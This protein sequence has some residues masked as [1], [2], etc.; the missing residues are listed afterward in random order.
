MSQTY[1]QLEARPA[2]DYLN[3]DNF[4]TASDKFPENIARNLAQQQFETGK[5]YGDDAKEVHI[6]VRSVWSASLKN[7]GHVSSYEGIGYHAGTAD[8]LRGFLASSAKVIVHRRCDDGLT[9]T[10]IKEAETPAE[11]K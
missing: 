1:A 5:K 8:L 9:E 10:V 4:V 6:S 2:S 11:M 7:G 3:P